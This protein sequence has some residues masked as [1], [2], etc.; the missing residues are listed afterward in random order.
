MSPNKIHV[1]GM[2]MNWKTLSREYLDQVEKADVLIGGTR[3]LDAFPG[4][5]GIRIPLK[6]PLAG[7]LAKAVEAMTAGKRVAVLADGDPLFFGIGRK[8]IEAV[9]SEHV[10]FFPNVTALQAAAAR[11]RIP[12]DRVKTVSLH[13]RKDLWPLLRAL[14]GANHVG[15]FTDRVNHPAA[16]ATELLR[17]EVH[18]FRMWVFENLWQED[19]RIGRYELDGLEGRSFSDLNFLILERAGSPKTRLRLGLSDDHYE[20]E[21]GLI[22]KR[23]IRAAGLSLLGIEPHHTV[24]DLGAGCGSVAIE[25][26]FLAREGAVYAVERDPSRSRMIRANI[27]RTGAYT[28]EPVASEMPACLDSLPDPDRVFIGGGLGQ[29][30]DTLSEALKRLKPGGRMVLH[31]VLLGSLSRVKRFLEEK[32]CAYTVTQI[33]VSRS[34]SLAGDERL[35]ALNPVYILSLTKQA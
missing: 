11:I 20:H 24:W 28:V 27:R 18:T 26:S 7:V 33:Q 30:V 9:G 17:R 3:Y 31:L 5:P 19:E 1:V 6:G 23:E 8:L 13:G 4:H 12:W 29:G 25:A 14:V 15:V 10:E 34:R 35:E 21:K 32:G 2:G 16:V 22:T